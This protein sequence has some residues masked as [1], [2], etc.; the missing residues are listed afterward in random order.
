LLIAHI[1][2]TLADL[3]ALALGA[4]GDA[5]RFARARGLRAVRLR[6]IG[7]YRLASG[8]HELSVNTVAAR[9]GVSP[10]YV[11]MLFEA[12]G[13]TFSRFVLASGSPAPIAC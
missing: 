10:R 12:E 4:S 2:T 7:R 9:Q 1:G 5:A 3:I 13:T 11:Q 8:E 6:A